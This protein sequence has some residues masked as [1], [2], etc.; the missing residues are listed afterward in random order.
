[1]SKIVNDWLNGTDED[2]E[3]TEKFG[4]SNDDDTPKSGGGGKSYNNLDD[5]FADLMS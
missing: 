4:A 2:D 3:G 5:A 1:M